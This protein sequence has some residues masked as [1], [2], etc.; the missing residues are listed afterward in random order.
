MPRS[1]DPAVAVLGTGLM[2]AAMARRWLGH[3]VAV[4]VWNRDQRRTEPLHAAGAAVAADPAAA[5]AAAGTV[6]TMLADGTATEAVMSAALAAM[7]PGALWVQMA[8]VG[9]DA[10]QR[11]A[12]L[13]AEHGV[14]FVDAPVSGTRQPAE[15]GTLTVLASGDAH[16]RDRCEALFAP[17]ATRTMWLGAAG[18]ATK[19]K[20]VVNAWLAALLSGLAE[21]VALAEGLG[22]DAQRFL[23]VI[24]GGPL[25]CGYATVK[26]GMMLRRDYPVSFPLH[27]LAKDVELVAAAA[28]GAGVPLRLPA[29]IAALLAAAGDHGDDDMAAVVE[30]LRTR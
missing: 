15:E 21:S 4:T 3:G 19:L 27:L 10:T 25:G 22:L 11:C 23:D 18:E 16:W 6:V 5:A 24:D 2:G 8:T 30:G 20:L 29:A 26:G 9:I 14:G 13:A 17:I 1:T 12:A 28:A 7:T